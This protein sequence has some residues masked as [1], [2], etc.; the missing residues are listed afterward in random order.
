MLRW[1]KNHP[2]EHRKMCLENQ[3]KAAAARRRKVKCIETGI[4]YESA[5][6]AARE[7]SKT[8]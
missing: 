6:A 4:I 8:S 2:E 7:V 5:T 3:K 1:Q